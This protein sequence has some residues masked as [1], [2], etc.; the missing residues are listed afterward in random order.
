MKYLYIITLALFTSCN[1]ANNNTDKNED[2]EAM[3]LTDKTVKFL[4]KQGSY[5]DEGNFKYMETVVDN[6]LYKTLSEPEIA[7]LGYVV[8]FIPSNCWWVGHF[9]GVHD[10]DMECYIL[11]ALDLGYQCSDKHLGFLREWF[12]NDTAS[13]KKFDECPKIPDTATNQGFF[14]EITLT[15]EG[16]K[17]SVSFKPYWM[18]FGTGKSWSWS[19]TNYFEFDGE[20]IKLIKQEES[21]VETWDAEM[22]AG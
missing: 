6:E 12:K 15:T 21:E 5:D 8:T 1:Q 7:A 20:H 14:E 16:N 10:T 13:L 3:S 4:W 11:S 9:K 22:S 18:S 2:I 19:E 17:I